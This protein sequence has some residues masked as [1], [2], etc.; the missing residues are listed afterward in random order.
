[1]NIGKPLK[2]IEVP[3]VQPKPVPVELPKKPEE[4]PILVPNWPVRQPAVVPV[5]VKR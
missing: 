4:M 3:M 2:I 1:M 5:P